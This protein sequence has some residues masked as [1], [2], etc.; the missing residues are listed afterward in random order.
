MTVYP[1][2]FTWTNQRFVPIDTPD[3]AEL[4]VA[5]SWR[6]QDGTS[7]G[8]S[9]HVQR[10]ITGMTAQTA[11]VRRLPRVDPTI[12]TAALAQQL[13]EVWQRH[14]A[15]ELFPRISLEP[16]HADWRVILLVRPAPAVRTTT[17][18][19]IPHYADPRTRPTVKG[20]DISLLRTL[21]S[22]VPTADDVVLHDGTNVIETTTG[23]L[24]V[25]DGP[26]DLALCQAPGQLASISA[27]RIT[28]HAKSQGITVTRRPVT[29]GQI[30]SG[31]YPVWFSNTLHGISPV[32][33]VAR[34]TGENPVVPHP[35]VA[36][37]QAA[38]RTQFRG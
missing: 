8:L 4:L 6:V 22:E 2:Y 5:D 9:E 28:T 29:I 36:Q 27:Q 3:T 25:W 20:P 7:W 38:W 24:L 15:T 11:R 35:S 37:W 19:W 12:F 30:A 23:A 31:E 21:V 17:R 16:Y 33:T 32:T 1:Q 10:F 13:L 34:D 26:E 14:P 18:L